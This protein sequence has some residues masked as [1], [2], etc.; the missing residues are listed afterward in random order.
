[1]G[2]APG[3][4]A[5]GSKRVQHVVAVFFGGLQPIAEVQEVILCCNALHLVE[6]A[7]TSPISRSSSKR[8]IGGTISMSRLDPQAFS[9]CSICSNEYP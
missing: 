1:M 8:S 3:T 9:A 7:H 6:G 2:E 5:S 4:R